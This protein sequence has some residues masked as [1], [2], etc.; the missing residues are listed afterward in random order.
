MLGD[1]LLAAV[2]DR[3]SRCVREGDTVARYGGDEF[4]VLLPQ[5]RHEADAAKI[6]EELLVALD[7]PFQ[8]DGLTLRVSAS[9]GGAVCHS[10]DEDVDSLLRAADSAMYRAKELETSCPLFHRVDPDGQP[11]CAWP[12]VRAGMTPEEA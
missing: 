8:V 11:G 12:S 5:M 6:A 7:E 2:A 10:G 9:V 1:K 4:V 3:L